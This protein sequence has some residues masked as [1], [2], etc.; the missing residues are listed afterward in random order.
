MNYNILMD[1][2][3]VVAVIIKNWIKAHTKAIP[4]QAKMKRDGSVSMVDALVSIL[5][6]NQLY[7]IIMQ[8]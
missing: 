1:I 8:Q 6:C 5:D 2:T 4:Q 3:Y 7:F